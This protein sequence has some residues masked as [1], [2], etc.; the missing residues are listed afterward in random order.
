MYIAILIAVLIIAVIEF[1]IGR[2]SARIEQKQKLKAVICGLILIN[3]ILLSALA[4]VLVNNY[5]L[6]LNQSSR[7]GLSL[8]PD[9]DKEKVAEDKKN[10]AA[11]RKLGTLA[12]SGDK[13]AVDKL[14][15]IAQEL[16]QGINYDKEHGRVI[17]NLTL[18]R[19]FF[20]ILGEEAG[21]GSKAAFDALMY[22]NGKKRIRVF[23]ADAFGIAAGMGNRDALKV[24]LEYSKYGFL[25]STVVYAMQPA[26]ENNI[27][28]A[29]DFM[30]GIIN[31]EHDKPLWFSA[32]EG[33]VGAA[34]KGNKKARTAIAKYSRNKEGY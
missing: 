15:K 23:T 4:L 28:E 6:R 11:M 33:L 22:A 26:A 13:A 27:P 29:V 14:E 19:A 2:I 8:L 10:I 24:L 31:N 25:Q 21:K 18:M 16:Y 34:Q 30:I 7:R 9:E 20:S 3:F 17:K 1:F 12:A 5:Q 32:S